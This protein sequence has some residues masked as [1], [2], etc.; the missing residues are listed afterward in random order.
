MHLVARIIIAHENEVLLGK[1]C[2][3]IESGRWSILGG[4]PEENEPPP[5]AACREVAEEIGIS[6]S[7]INYLFSDQF[8]DWLSQ[9]FLAQLATKPPSLQINKNEHS[10]VQWFNWEQIEECKNQIAFN[11]Y[12][13]L[14]KYYG[15]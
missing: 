4:K 11:H 2:N 10:H 8:N 13:I 12:L 7:K 15:Y 5:Q 6:V 1:R 14:K 3:G 9:Y